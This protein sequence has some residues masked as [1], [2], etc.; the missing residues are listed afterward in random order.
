MNEFRLYW[1][2]RAPA[3]IC[4]SS[5]EPRDLF[6]GSYSIC[7]PIAKTR[8]S[9]ASCSGSC[10]S[11]TCCCRKLAG[12]RCCDWSRGNGSRSERLEGEFYDRYKAVRERLFNVLRLN[13]PAFP[14]F[15]TDLL[16]LTQ[17]LLD[18]FIFAFYCEDMGERMLFPPQ[19][20]RDHLKAAAP[21]HIYD[22]NAGEFWGFFQALVSAS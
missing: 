11:A 9:T 18:R 15:P 8:A 7:S 3:N 12:R 22:P 20:I 1:W 16:R 13:N 10:F 21:S 17:K 6:S 2:D 19:M 14:G 5:S 4:G